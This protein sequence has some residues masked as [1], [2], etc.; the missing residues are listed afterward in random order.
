MLLLEML[1]LVVFINILEI[2]LHLSNLPG[3][4]QDIDHNFT[5]VFL[6]NLLWSGDALWY[7]AKRS[8][9]VQGQIATKPSPAPML[10]WCSQEQKSVKFLT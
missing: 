3:S 4:K 7:H 1:F 8:P 9:L 10:T 5:Q 6:F 2:N